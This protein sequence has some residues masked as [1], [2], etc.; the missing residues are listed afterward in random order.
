MSNSCAGEVKLIYTCSGAADVGEIADKVARRLRDESFGALT[1]LA[2]IGAGLSGFIASAKGSSECIAI[3]GCP[4]ACAKKALEN[5]GVKPTSYIL[6]EM[7][8]TKGKTP[9]TKE[10]IE[11]MVSAIKKGVTNIGLS[12]NKSTCSC[13]G[14]C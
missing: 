9:V 14:K 12:E 1:C 11:Q 8:L 10:V 3:D 6:T 5:L 4:V 13:G 2:G 7:G